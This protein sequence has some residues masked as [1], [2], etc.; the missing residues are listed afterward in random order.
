MSFLFPNIVE[1]SLETSL[2]TLNITGQQQPSIP[3]LSSGDDIEKVCERE[4][5][6]VQ[7]IISSDLFYR[8]LQNSRYMQIIQLVLHLVHLIQTIIM[9][10]LILMLLLIRR[11]IVSVYG[12]YI[13]PV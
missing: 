9:N 11:T 8:Y 5:G 10:N 2:E 4:K 12:I 1:S 3:H 13:F 6:I 7:L